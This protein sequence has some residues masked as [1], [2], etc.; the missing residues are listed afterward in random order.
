MRKKVNYLLDMCTLEALCAVHYSLF[1]NLWC[2]YYFSHFIGKEPEDHRL[3][4]LPEA[5]V[6]T[7]H[8]LLYFHHSILLLEP[9]VLKGRKKRKWELEREREIWIFS[10]KGTQS[11]PSNYGPGASL[12]IVL[13][14]EDFMACQTGFELWFSYSRAPSL[15]PGLSELWFPH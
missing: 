6:S 2:G 1:T 5:A 15:S 9:R 14:Q 8:Q 4:N 7:W 12:Q 13:L 11:L 10:G 3:N